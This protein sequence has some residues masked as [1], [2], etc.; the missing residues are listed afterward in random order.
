MEE[1]IAL[2]NRVAVFRAGRIE[3]VL[4]EK[5]INEAE[6]IKLSMGIE[7]EGGAEDE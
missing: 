7:E 6:I 5:D 3:G 2:S 4:E 1:L